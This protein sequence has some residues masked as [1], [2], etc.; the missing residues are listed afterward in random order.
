MWLLI[1]A[2]LIA[3]VVAAFASG[4]GLADHESLHLV[5]GVVTGD[6]LDLYGGLEG[7]DRWPY[8]PGYVPAILGAH[9]FAELTGLGFIP[10]IRLAP[11]ASDLGLALLVQ[12]LLGLRGASERAR[13]AAT[14]AVAL[15]PVFMGVSSYQAQIDSLAILPALAALMVWERDGP[16]RALLAGL[17]IGA[18]GSVKTIPLVVVLALL[19]WCRSPREAVTLVAA[20]AAV[21][22][23]LLA[24]YLAIDAG[25]VLDH[26]SYRGF[27][28]LGGISLLVQPELPLLPISGN[29]FEPNAATDLLL[30]AGGVL[31]L[32]ALAATAAFLLRF[33]PPPLEAAILIW[34]VLWVF[35]VNFFL[36]Y[37]VWG[38]PFLLVAGDLRRVVQ[39][40]LLAVPA[41]AVFYLE[42]D[43]DWAVWV[44]YTPPV[45]AIWAL[46]VAM[47][48]S[49]A[50]ASAFRPR[51]TRFA[52]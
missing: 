44:F 20:A 27:A 16:R 18:G 28:G 31:P 40:Q 34:L 6:P 29:G 8:P 23:A 32:L 25:D 45:V 33:R 12:H 36:Q 14:A 21:P 52:H 7:E 4:E 24:P 22:L 50:R 47:L 19:P 38:L 11:I 43:A 35:G 10:L 26:L 17:L 46:S 41:L 48:V 39:I 2:G 1:G 30:D 3:R 42:V 13:V 37:L 49:R 5:R 15:G 9:G 51:S